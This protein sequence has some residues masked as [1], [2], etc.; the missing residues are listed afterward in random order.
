VFAYP[1]L[2]SLV[3]T[4]PG[5]TPA[6][7][8]L[9]AFDAA[10]GSAVGI[11]SKS[12]PFRIDFRSGEV[13]RETATRLTHPSSIDGSAVFGVVKS[14]DVVRLT[15]SGKWSVKPPAPA[16]DAIPLPDGS[17]LILSDEGKSTALWRVRPPQTQLS[18]TAVLP[19]SSRVVAGPLGDRA[20]VLV[21]SGLI[22]LSIRDLARVPNVQLGSPIRAAVPTPSGDRLYAAPDSS[23]SIIIVDRYNG[24][25]DRQIALPGHAIDLR[26]DP[27][28]RYVLARAATGD[29]AWIV[30]VGTDKV[31]GTVLT[32]W[33][34]DLP[35]VAPDGGILL[36]RKNDVA[37]VDGETLKPRSVI[38]NGGKDAW[39]IVAWNGFRPRAAGLDEPVTFPSDSG[40]VDSTAAPRPPAPP[41]SAPPETTVVQR[42]PARDTAWRGFTVQFAALRDNAAAKQL[43]TEIAVNGEKAHVV[44]TTRD[45]ITVYRVVLGPYPTRPD[46]DRVAKA[47]GRS[48]WIYEGQP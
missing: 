4:A 36:L 26:M 6:L 31:I 41:D 1:Q 32:A 14:G 38:T 29:S 39:M 33:R 43:A 3:W 34:R 13:T 35:A 21:D 17:L 40:G 27:T 5:N 19:R 47:A 30:A 7:D 11:D 15:P 10:A 18:D 48:S 42:P 44:A 46:A 25:V 22:V 20:Y 28:G 24:H 23:A 9:L 8:E 2:D 12:A 16:R 45:G 37:V